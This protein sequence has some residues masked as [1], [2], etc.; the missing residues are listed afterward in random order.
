MQ[1]EYNRI[2]R[3]IFGANRRMEPPAAPQ[4]G[5]AT[6]DGDAN[7]DSAGDSAAPP[8][9]HPYVTIAILILLTLIFVMMLAA[10]QNDIGRVAVQFGAKDNV[11]IQQGQ[12]WRLIT[13]IFLHGGWLHLLV[14]GFSLF[15]LGGSMERIYGPKKYLLIFLFAGFTGN[16]LSYWLSPTLSLGASGALFGLVGAGLVFPIRFRSLINPEAR[17]SILRQLAS[18]AI[19]NLAIGFSLQGIIDNWAHIGGLLGG[20]FA[21]LFLIPDVLERRPG[22]FVANSVLT[23]LV[24]LSIGTVA[25]AWIF[26]WRWAHENPSIRVVSYVPSSGPPW[27]SVNVPIR[28]KYTNGVWL[29]PDG[30][31]IRISE[32]FVGDPATQTELQS[33]AVEKKPLNTELDGKRGW[34]LVSPNRLQY[35]IPIYDRLFELS[36]DAP[37]RDLNPQA[38]KDFDL[39]AKSIRFVLPPVIIRTQPNPG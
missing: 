31:T 7:S 24:L 27:W 3:N 6:H 26:Q 1:P 2:Y 38:K 39:V 36:L 34:Y 8:A 4:R 25:A 35:R 16:L 10:G 15:S 13:P 29:A 9:A 37:V 21:A 12:W 22:S 19:I 5:V 30:S 14:N 32:H 23:A 11:L 33:L 20:A 17:T 18:V 28:W